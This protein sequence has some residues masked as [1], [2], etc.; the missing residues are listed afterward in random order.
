[1][2]SAAGHVGYLNLGES[3]TRWQRR[4]RWSAART[5]ER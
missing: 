5:S 4:I 2:N 3:Q 1:M